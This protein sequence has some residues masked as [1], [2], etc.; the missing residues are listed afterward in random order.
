LEYSSGKIV[1]DERRGGVSIRTRSF[2]S[3][4]AATV[5]DFARTPSSLF[6]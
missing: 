5:D 4:K 1:S 3:A 6:Q 2:T